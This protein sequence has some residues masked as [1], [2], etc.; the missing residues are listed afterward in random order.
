MFSY[1]GQEIRVGVPVSKSFPPF[2]IRDNVTNQIS[3]FCMDVTKEILNKTGF[4]G[5][6]SFVFDSFDDLGKNVNRL[7]SRI[8][9][10]GW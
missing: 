8:M 1:L 6:Y 2:Y 5:N 3:G 4:R 10:I 7:N 9:Y